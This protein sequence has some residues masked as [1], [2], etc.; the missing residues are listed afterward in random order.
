MRTLLSFFNW[1]KH[2]T[3][4]LYLALPLAVMGLA[5]SALQAILEGEQF[6]RWGYALI[7]AAG[8]TLLGVA[9]RPAWRLFR[10]CESKQNT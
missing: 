2:P 5:L 8:M 9:L 1:K 3:N 10:V 6:H 7:W 4:V